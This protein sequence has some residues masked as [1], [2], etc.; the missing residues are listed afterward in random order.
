MV[1][2]LLRSQRKQRALDSLWCTTRPVDRAQVLLA[3]TAVH[4][5][6]VTHRDVKPENL[7]VGP[8]GRV[9]LIDFG[10]AVDAYST[11]NLYGKA[12]PSELEQTVEYAPPE[13]VFGRFWGGKP[14]VRRTWPYDMWSLGVVWLELL[15]GTPHVFQ[16]SARTRAL[17]DAR[18]RLER[19]SA[20][21]RQQIYLLRG[22]MELCIYPPTLPAKRKEGG[23]GEKGQ[24]GDRQQHSVLQWSCSEPALLETLRSRDPTGTG[25][26]SVLEL[27]LLRALL[28]WQPS[29]RPTATEALR[30]AAFTPAGAS[31]REEDLEGCSVLA[32]S[33]LGWC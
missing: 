11:L 7:L 30:H 28:H 26:G 10:S 22:M 2:S 32:R 3:L 14:V 17:L 9:R 31:T 1:Q 15:L 12:G 21:D 4:G 29:E 19:K 13:T 24:E 20:E 18:L 25:L 23:S 8:A 16:I 5:H 6:N 27:R 33:Q